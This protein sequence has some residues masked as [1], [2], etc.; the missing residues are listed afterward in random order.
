MV[1]F[2]PVDPDEV[3][4]FREGRRGRVSYPILKS[5]LETNL[6][7]AKLDRTGM[8]NSMQSLSSCLNS[9]IRSHDIPVRI[10][11]RSGEMYLARTDIDENG[12][13]I[14]RTE[15]LGAKRPRQTEGHA[16]TEAYLDAVPLDSAEV[17]ARY[18]EEKGQVTK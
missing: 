10:F 4:N 7:V 11:Q 2:L 8:Q 12:N 6:T 17:D 1:K 14:E 16:P 5:F 18:K 13:F 3:P 9:Y 15:E